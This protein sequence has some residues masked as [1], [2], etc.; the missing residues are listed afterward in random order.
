MNPCGGHQSEPRFSTHT[1]RDR[2]TPARHRPDRADHVE[3]GVVDRS[4]RRA[5]IDG[6]DR[7]PRSV[8]DRSGR[9]RARNRSA[10]KADKALDRLLVGGGNRRGRRSPGAALREIDGLVLG[11]A[12][13]TEAWP[14][15]FVATGLLAARLLRVEDQIDVVERRLQPAKRTELLDGDMEQPRIP[16]EGLVRPVQPRIELGIP[17][18]LCEPGAG[19]GP[20]PAACAADSALHPLLRRGPGATGAVRWRAARRRPAR[21]STHSSQGR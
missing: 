11:A 14:Q 17:G 2:S 7:L 19:V 20:D 15:S 5:S 16:D 10:R 3:C 1:S 18:R 6:F 12:G 21:G 4:R 13:E 8:D 9:R